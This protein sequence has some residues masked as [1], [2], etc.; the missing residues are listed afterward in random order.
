MQGDALRMMLMVT[1]VL[2]DLKIPYAVGGSMSSSLHGIMRSTMDVDILADLHQEQVPAF[3]SAV[4]GAFYADEEMITDAIEHRSSFNL[5]HLETAYK[6]D[7]FIP[8]E[9][10]F[11]KMQLERRV[12]SAVGE[13]PETNIYVT[14]PE[15]IILAKLEWYR[16][17]GELS[18]RQWRDVL[19]VVK[20]Q[21]GKLDISYMQKLAKLMTVDD[22]LERVLREAG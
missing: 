21:A 16:M 2:E 11:D 8:K 13:D 22:L 10:M 12:V 18:E 20:T 9:R 6:V 5:I 15:D 4:S 17:G 1:S 19:G 14:S 3:I 7:I